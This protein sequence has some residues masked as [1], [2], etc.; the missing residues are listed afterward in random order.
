MARQRPG[1][2]TR[3]GAGKAA[4]GRGTFPDVV[5]AGF[6]E[7]TADSPTIGY[8]RREGHERHDGAAPDARFDR[9]GGPA[10][11]GANGKVE[12]TTTM[13]QRPSAGSDPSPGRSAAVRSPLRWGS[14]A[15]RA[16]RPRSPTRRRRCRTG[17]EGVVRPWCGDGWSGERAGGSRRVA[18]RAVFVR[19]GPAR[20]FVSAAIE[21]PGS[22]VGHGG[23]ALDRCRRRARAGFGRSPRGAAGPR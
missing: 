15:G 19:F 4:V 13:L 3:P 1:R 16:R 18:E 22:K 7:A 6:P 17:R 2:A 8:R 12:L 9:P 11:G 21:T 14:A 20:R 10:M 23:R 5:G